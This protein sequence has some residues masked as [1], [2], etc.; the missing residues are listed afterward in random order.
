MTSSRHKYF[1]K[2]FHVGNSQ[3]LPFLAD[4]VTQIYLKS[5]FIQR[6]F[7]LDHRD[8]VPTECVE[9]TMLDLDESYVRE[10][11]SFIVPALMPSII[12]IQRRSIVGINFFIG[13]VLTVWVREKLEFFGAGNLKCGLYTG[14]TCLVLKL[15]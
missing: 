4:H 10:I 12:N 9:I 13:Q 3:V 7:V 15:V 1:L 11:K 14:N 2:W 6:V 8:M 5:L